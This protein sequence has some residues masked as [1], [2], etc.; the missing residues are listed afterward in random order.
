[1]NTKI[2]EVQNKIC[3]NSKSITTQEFKKLTAED[4]GA[5][6]KQANLVKKADLITN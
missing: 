4:F 3:N 2:S 1:M 5:R 6:L